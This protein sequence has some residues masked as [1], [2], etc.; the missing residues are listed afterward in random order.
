M[1]SE[2]DL[3]IPFE[4]NRKQTPIQAPRCA[5]P[6]IKQI[7]NRHPPLGNKKQ[8]KSE[9]VLRAPDPEPADAETKIQS[10]DHRQNPFQSNPINTRT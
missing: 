4:I 9:D 7:R 2:Q 1:R 8:Q 10:G 3:H 6:Q 5:L